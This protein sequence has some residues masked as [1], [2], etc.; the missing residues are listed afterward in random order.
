MVFRAVRRKNKFAADFPRNG[1]PREQPGN[2]TQA[3]GSLTG[4]GD[5]PRAA[6]FE[7]GLE[8]SGMSWTIK[9]KLV[10]MGVAALAV[11]T[12]LV[13]ISYFTNNT[14]K[15]ASRKNAVMLR[16]TEVLSDLRVSS[17]KLVLAAQD[18]IIDADEGYVYDERLEVMDASITA[19]RDAQEVIDAVATGAGRP[20]LV[21]QVVDMTNQADRVVRVELVQ[22]IEGGVE[23]EVLAQFDDDID[24][25]GEG[26]VKLMEELQDLVAVDLAASSAQLEKTAE[27]ATNIALLAWL[28]G[29][30]GLCIFLLWQGR[31]IIVPI[32]RL[33]DAMGELADGRLDVEIAG[34]GRG[35]EVGQMAGTVQVFKENAVEK[36]R[37]E[38]EQMAAQQHAEEEKRQGM[39]E[40]AD[41]FER[42]VKEVVD[43]VS[44]SA[45]EMQATAQQMSSTAEE[46]S[47]QSA[48]VATASEEATANVQTV[49]ATAEELSV[50]ISEIGRQVGQSATI[51]GNAVSAADETSETIRGLS[52]AAGKIG[53]VVNLINEIANQTNLLALNATIEAARA[54]EAGKGFAVVAQ[55]V[56][57]LAT[58]TAKATEDISA[59]IGAVQEETEGAVSAIA[60]IRDIIGEIDDISMT[61][62]TAVEQQGASTQEIARTV[63]QAAKGTQD[64]NSNIESVSKAAGETGTAAGQVLDASRDM[65]RRAEGLRAEVD[66][67]L[68]EV[69]SA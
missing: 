44:S 46:V 10:S 54:G 49:A 5:G 65:A 35:D 17:I 45:T 37:L 19:L 12:V 23:E 38:E 51:A 33:T 66:K 39:N 24:E 61:I 60:K 27:S 69:R 29:G 43:G 47:R 3:P 59:Q 2:D 15:Q 56:K 7:L 40:L 21:K 30:G 42:Q 9:L 6:N 52:E 26:L 58:Q 22:A 48:N 57:N 62:S 34:L 67:F 55:E 32:R 31:G 13:G 63:Q 18:S 20:E 50:S 14:V 8:F 1:R 64:V 53:E 41:R 28:I 16:Q 4:R 68:A 25:Y 36:I 11:L